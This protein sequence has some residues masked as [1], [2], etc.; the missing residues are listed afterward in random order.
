MFFNFN[1]KKDLPEKCDLTPYVN[2][3]EDT[4]VVSCCFWNDWKGLVRETIHI[5][6]AGGKALFQIPSKERGII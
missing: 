5:E 4:A 3:E 1:I 6:F 2:M